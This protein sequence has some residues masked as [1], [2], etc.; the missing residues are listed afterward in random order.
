MEDFSY[1]LKNELSNYS[2]EEKKR[3]LREYQKCINLLLQALETT[4]TH[5][6]YRKN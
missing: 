5:P 1:I 2:K 4:N 3:I 6:T